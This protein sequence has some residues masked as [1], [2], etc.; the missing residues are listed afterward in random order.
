MTFPALF[1][2]WLSGI[3]AMIA[4]MCFT[5]RDRWFALFCAMVAFALV[6]PAA[7]EMLR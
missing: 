2:V 5:N 1:L 6:A 4:A 3:M 7:A